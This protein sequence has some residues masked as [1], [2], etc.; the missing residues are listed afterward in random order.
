VIQIKYH[1]LAICLFLTSISSTNTEEG[2]PHGNTGIDHQ[3]MPG[4]VTSL[5]TG[6]I[7]RAVSDIIRRSRPVDRQNVIKVLGKPLGAEL[8]FFG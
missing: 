6:Q 8:V 1:S 5:I 2:H 7:Q 3:I 4:G